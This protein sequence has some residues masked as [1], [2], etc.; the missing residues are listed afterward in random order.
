MNGKSFA[1]SPVD[2]RGVFDH[3]FFC[4][5]DYEKETDVVR[6]YLKDEGFDSKSETFFIILRNRSWQCTPIKSS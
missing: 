3:D 4:S 6:Q 2:E 5:E 1:V